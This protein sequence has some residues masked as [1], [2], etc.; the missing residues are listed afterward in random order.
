MLIDQTGRMP[1][2]AVPMDKEEA[3]ELARLSAAARRFRTQRDRLIASERS[4]G[5]SL[6]AIAAAAKLSP[7][8][9]QNIVDR[10][11]GS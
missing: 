3:R 10:E 2:K 8:Q 7:Q 5:V 6:R 1:R 11:A 9:V 4:K